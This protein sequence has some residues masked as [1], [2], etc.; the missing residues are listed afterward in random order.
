MIARTQKRRFIF[1]AVLGVLSAA[2]L[3]VP[4]SFAANGHGGTRAAAT[5]SSC[6]QGAP[7]VVVQNNYAW[8]AWGSWGLPGQ[9]LA[10]DLQV[11]NYDVGCGS[12]SFV[13][14]VSTPSGFS[15]SMPS[16]TISVASSS[17]GY[18]WAY[19]TS[20][21]G[22]ADGDYPLTVTVARGGATAAVAAAT[23]Y[24]K[25]YSFD[26]TA[27]TLFWMNPGNG[28]TISGKSYTLNASSSDDHAVR[29]IELFIDGMYRTTA[30]CD[31]VTYICQ[32]TY[33]W[34]LSH[35]RGSHTATFNSYDWMGNVAVST[36]SFMVSR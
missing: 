2:L 3:I 19:V 26:T 23:S 11:V 14:T 28:A 16:N 34:S 33:T 27:P 24:Y 35:A 21:S 29:K 8:S 31:G 12:S 7:A 25:L 17:S 36:V 30:T 13:V 10:Y 1:L 5:T 9:Q 18:L 22:V 32:L 4:A 20:P 15:V 6:V